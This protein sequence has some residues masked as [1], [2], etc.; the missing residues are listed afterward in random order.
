MMPAP[1]LSSWPPRKSV[2]VAAPAPAPKSALPPGVG[3]AEVLVALS[4]LGDRVAGFEICGVDSDLA[5]I[6]TLGNELG[7]VLRQALEL[8]RLLERLNNDSI[9][10]DNELSFDQDVTPQARPGVVLNG[11]VM[12]RVGDV[13]FAG[14]L[15]LHRARVALLGAKTTDESLVAAETALR[16][17][18]RV[19][20]AVLEAARAEG[21]VEIAG[22]EHR[23]RHLVA[24]LRS[25]LGVRRLYAGFRRA[26]RRPDSDDP[27]AVL[28]ALRYA[29]GALAT[30]STSEAYTGVRAADRSLFRRL[31]ER[32]LDWSRSGR[33]V[34]L[35][36]QL[37]DDVWTC[38]DLLRGVNRR[39]EL[40]A[41]DSTLI[42][43]LLATPAPGD[44]S[45]L[46]QLNDLIG[47]DDTLDVLIERTANG[48]DEQSEAELL[49]KL[50]Q[51]R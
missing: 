42:T 3:S 30:V 45:W 36:L 32:L 19:V 23:R 34:E 31:R 44:K 13:C 4:E 24:D 49:M 39:Q 12:P 6:G 1:S 7:D 10:E 41:H 33:P 14:T 51:L 35:G 28:M 26:L 18:R 11:P 48:A 22:G 27:E 25:A 17:V 50:E 2:P 15:E 8:L 9:P 46:A 20:H 38:A 37:L 16:K 21:A 29:A 5:A 47:L 43:A 40:R